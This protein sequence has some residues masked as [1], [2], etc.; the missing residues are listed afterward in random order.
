MDALATLINLLGDQDKKDFKAF[1]RKKNKRHDVKNILLFEL[2]NTDDINGLEKLLKK[3][4][5]RDSYH[6]LRKRLHDSLLLFL[7]QKTFES[8]NS[9]ASEVMRLIV[10]SRYLLEN[11][12]DKTAFKCL[13]KAEQIA[14]KLEQYNLLNDI[15]LLKI[16]YAHSA[17]SESLEALTARFMVNQHY[18]QREAK[19]N[20]AYAFLRQEMRDVNLK[21]K[22]VNLKVLMLGTIR[23]YQIAVKDLMN[24]KSIYQ[25]LFIA[26][27]YAAI[28]Q[29][30]S[31]I[32]RYIQR[33]QYFIQGNTKT[34]ELHLFYQLHVLYFLAN[35]HLRNKNFEK[36]TDY[37]AEMKSKMEQHRVYESQFHP[38]HQLLSA[39]NLYFTGKGAAGTAVLLK[40]LELSTKKTKQEDIEDLRI[41]LT[42]FLSLQDDKSCLRHLALFQHS[43][44]WYEKKMGMLWTIRKNLMEVLVHAQFDHIELA[45]S[46]L[47]SFKRR[48]SAFLTETH[49]E[50]VLHFVNLVEKY[51]NKPD[52]IFNA[53][54]QKAVMNL[55]KNKDHSDLFHSCF[56]SWLIAKWEKKSAY[57]IVLHHL[58]NRPIP[59]NIAV[60]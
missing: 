19:L 4:K 28:H 13:L 56:I 53:V 44:P 23:K 20:L 37:L 36:S 25:I 26:N 41:C 3:S 11:D 2:L 32:E 54:F 47:N 55:F 6:A 29:D 57:E 49:E 22:V 12:L 8:N 33:I 45:V 43:D 9:Q 59:E 10:V 40:T 58:S 35:F 21:G 31:F 50:R 15:L 16:H 42:M 30:Y 46:R 34:D 5:N 18:M 51:F 48:Y 14:S 7:S 1:M 27:E 17:E 52:V 60:N 39:L 24:Y 38:R